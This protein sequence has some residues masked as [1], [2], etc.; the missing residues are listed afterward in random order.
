MFPHQ[1]GYRPL[2]DLLR[3]QC[4]KR[5]AQVPWES[6]NGGISR[7]GVSW[8]RDSSDWEEG[9]NLAPYPGCEWQ[10]GVKRGERWGWRGH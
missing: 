5:R 2:G 3:G 9:T 6:V 8:P 10:V 4:P 1:F 7:E